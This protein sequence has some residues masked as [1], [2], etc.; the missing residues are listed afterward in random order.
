[1]ANDVPISSPELLLKALRGDDV[2]S[3]NPIDFMMTVATLNGVDT[4]LSAPQ[5]LVIS[6]TQKAAKKLYQQYICITARCLPAVQVLLVKDNRKHHNTQPGQPHVLIST[7]GQLSA[8]L[9]SKDINCQSVR[10]VVLNDIKGW[11]S[12]TKEAVGQVMMATPHTRQVK[13]A[14][15]VLTT[16]CRNA[17]KS[18]LQDPDEEKDSNEP[19][20]VDS[21]TEALDNLAVMKNKD[22][23][24]RRGGLLLLSKLFKDK[25]QQS[26]RQSFAKLVEAFGFCYA[27][28]SNICISIHNPTSLEPA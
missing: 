13:L 18:E 19:S 11:T 20:L 12:S 22:Q 7:P 9:R 3:Q 24:L 4:M 10:S 5:V 16:V 15:A 27:H 28:S 25:K 14:M 8:L 2:M 1:M 26:M 6:N 21:E 17:A 23:K